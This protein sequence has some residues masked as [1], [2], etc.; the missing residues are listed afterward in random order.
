MREEKIK[1]TFKQYCDSLSRKD[2]HEEIKSMIIYEC[3]V[4]SMTFQNWKSGKT[5]PGKLAQEKISML[6]N[7]PA[8]KLF[9]K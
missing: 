4:T 3:D 1:M 9:P 6:T 2:P 5:V 8:N 7:I